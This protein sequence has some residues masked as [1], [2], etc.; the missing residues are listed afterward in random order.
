MGHSLSIVCLFLASLALA[1]SPSLLNAADTAGSQFPVQTPKPH[2]LAR[3]A[4][5]VARQ[6]EHIRKTVR[7]YTCVLVKRERIDDE[8][9]GYQYISAKVRRGF[10][11]DNQLEHPF[12]VQLTYLGPQRMRGCVVFFREGANNNDMLVRRGGG[13]LR[14]ITLK[15]SPDSVAAR[16]ES[17]MPIT[18]TGFEQMARSLADRISEEMRLDPT[19]ENTRVEYFKRARLDDRLCTRILV[20]H[21]RPAKGLIFHTAEFFLDDELQLPLRV[22]TYGFPDGAHEP[23]LLSEFNYTR[24]RLNVG[25]TAADF[26]SWA[27]A[28]QPASNP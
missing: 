1:T 5:I 14:R 23:P 11:A 10:T 21:P 18:D 17:L 13:F 6:L 16:R 7:D 19:G 4:E 9:Q 3:P 2:P 22:V 28:E 27:T 12:Q 20:T 26:V 15:I 25:L 24:L 8:L